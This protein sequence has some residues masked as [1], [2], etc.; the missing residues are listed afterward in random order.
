[1]RLLAFALILSL[2]QTAWAEVK[3]DEMETNF[4]DS[5]SR[6]K[7]VWAGPGVILKEEQYGWSATLVETDTDRFLAEKVWP[8]VDEGNVWLS[9]TDRPWSPQYAIAKYLKALVEIEAEK[10]RRGK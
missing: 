9:N 5:N 7:K 6:I 4:L 10:L 3:V 8:E 2:S 1:M